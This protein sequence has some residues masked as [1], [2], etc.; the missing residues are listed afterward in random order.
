MNAQRAVE[1][2]KERF[3]D[4]IR[5]VSEFRDRLTVRV[6]RQSIRDIG[7]FLRDDEELRFDMSIDIL[8][9]DRLVPGNKPSMR[10]YVNDPYDRELRSHTEEIP[11]E[12]RFEVVYILYS[13]RNKEYIHLKVR[14][15]ES[16][17][18]VPSVV[19]VW[20]T[21]NWQERETYDMFGIE[22]DGHPD[23]RRIYMPDYFEYFPL[24]KDFPLLGIPGSLPLP[25]KQ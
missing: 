20:P 9:T 11:V 21:S 16:G 3:P 5:D 10:G 19:S 8:G 24:R 14:V 23:L 6:D 17:E 12:E 1:K 7:L 18:K 15:A 13:N 4:A 22:F 25:D 2:L